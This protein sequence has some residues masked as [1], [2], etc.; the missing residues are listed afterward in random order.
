MEPQRVK[1]AGGTVYRAASEE[2]RL[3][4][5]AEWWLPPLIG[6]GAAA[7]PMLL[8]LYVVALTAR[9]DLERIGVLGIIFMILIHVLYG[10]TA[11]MLVRRYGVVRAV[12][13]PICPVASLILAETAFLAPSEPWVFILLLV[14][15]V[16]GALCVWLALWL[17]ARKAPTGP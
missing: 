10:G 7:V 2:Q 17:W 11:G 9:G 16:L 13:I 8:M 4:R 6:A 14:I 15:L 12:A 1:P 3:E 5:L